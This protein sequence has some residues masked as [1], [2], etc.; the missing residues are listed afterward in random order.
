[1]RRHAL[2]H[3]R[4]P[5]ALSGGGDVFVDE[6]NRGGYLLC[7]AVVPS[8]DIA[9]ARAAMRPLKPGNRRRLHMHSEGVVRRQQILARF[10][11]A[12][13]ITAAHLWR[14]PIRGRPE[15][16]A[17]DDCF[18]ALVT[19]VLE[20][21]ARRIVVESCSQDRQDEQII[22]ATLAQSGA[23][24]RVNYAVIPAE[25]DELLW[26]ADLITWAYRAGGDAREAI[27]GLLTVH[28]L[29]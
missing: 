28:D 23:I 5:V 25:N 27:A 19:A 8:A 11:A 16:D 22:G 7:A 14:A 24:G 9:A 15:R 26:A 17:P 29:P 2:A 3:K 6:G 10:A 4:R 21:D 1:V 13:P 18:R 20:L 12:P